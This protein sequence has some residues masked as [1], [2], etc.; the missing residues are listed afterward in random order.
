MSVAARNHT[1]AI[2]LQTNIIVEMPIKWIEASRF[3]SSKKVL[4]IQCAAKVMFIVAYDIDAD[5]TAPRCTSKQTVNAAYYCTF[6]PHH[7][8]PAL[9]RKRR[10][11]M[12]QNPIILHD[13]A[14]SHTVAAVNGRFW[15]IHR[16]HLIRIHA[17]TI[18]SPKWKNHCEGRS[19]IQEMNLSVLWDGQYVKSRNMDAL[20]VY[21]AFKTFGKG[22]K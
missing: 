16:T 3:S 22:D 2:I 14:R 12:V 19:T 15:N 8:H 20:M 10:H 9:R 4:P 18:S 6:L 17:I 11:L 21:E 7:L 5:N 13:N 1:F